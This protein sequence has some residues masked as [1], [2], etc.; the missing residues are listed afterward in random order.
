MAKDSDK[1][2]ENLP[3]EL[4]EEILTY[5]EKKD[6]LMPENAGK[7]ALI[8]GKKIE[9]IFESGEDATKQGYERF[10]NVPFLVKKIVPF[11]PPLNFTA[12][13]IGA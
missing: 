12:N 11:E 4:R 6:S 10:G 8:K 1:I 7:Y 5:F 2:T 3:S 9:G 13:M